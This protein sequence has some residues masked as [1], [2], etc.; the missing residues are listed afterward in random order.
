MWKMIDWTPEIDM[1]SLCSTSFLQGLG[2]GFVF[3]PLQVVSFATLEAKY[4]G[5]AAAILSLIRN[6]GSA[7]GIS[8]SSFLL[9]QS[10]QIMHARIAE[11][12]TPYNRMLQTGG[13]SLFWNDLNPAGLEGLNAEVT[14][15]ATIIAYAN[16][17][18]FLLWVSMPSALLLLLLRK[19]GAR[20]A[21]A[22]RPAA[23][24][25]HAA[26]LD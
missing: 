10:T 4:R 20:P 14:R 5:D 8:I 24:P 2:L 7:V 19:P 16:D 1:W 25:E 11:S 13:A 22:A 21:V 6:V 9:V 15:Q 18:K 23:E 26:V 12:V 17:F 3:I